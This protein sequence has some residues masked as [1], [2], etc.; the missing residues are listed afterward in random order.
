LK[1]L[2][3]LT[4]A[5]V[6]I[7]LEGEKTPLSDLLKY[8]FIH[9]LFKHVLSIVE[10]QRQPSSRDPVRQYKY[11]RIGGNFRSYESKLHE[12]VFLSIFQ[13]KSESMYCLETL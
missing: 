8:T 2:S 10:V 12:R 9:L 5:E 6:L 13:A 1:Y 3:R 7:I 4:P 11:I